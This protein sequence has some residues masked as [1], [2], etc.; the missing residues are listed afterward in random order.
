MLKHLQCFT[1]RPLVKTLGGPYQGYNIN[2]Y[3]NTYIVK[4]VHLTFMK[5]EN[6]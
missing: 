2:Y 5:K 1:R 3:G 6:L 4:N